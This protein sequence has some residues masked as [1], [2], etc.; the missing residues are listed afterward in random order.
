MR[1]KFLHFLASFWTDF[2]YIPKGRFHNR[3]RFL[4][5]YHRCT[6]AKLLSQVMARVAR[7]L[8]LVHTRT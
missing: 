4:R 6:R 5:N 2:A 3:N 7:I 8:R 1:G